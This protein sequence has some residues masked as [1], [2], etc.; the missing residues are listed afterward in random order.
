M[1]KK[2]YLQIPMKLKR[3]IPIGIALLGVIA[4]SVVLATMDGFLI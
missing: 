2:L 1:E 4:A 3:T